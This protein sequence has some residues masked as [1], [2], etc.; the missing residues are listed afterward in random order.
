MVMMAMTFDGRVCEV[1]GY[2]VVGG[3]VIDVSPS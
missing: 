3:N 1:R 2:V